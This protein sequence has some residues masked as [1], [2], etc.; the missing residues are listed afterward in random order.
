[1]AT[2]IKF[3]TDEHIAKAVIRGLRQRGVDVL[4]LVEAG[5][6]GALD[7]KHLAFALQQGR[8]IFTQ[9][10]D[11]L[12]FHGQG[13]EHAGIVYAPQGTAIGVIIRGLMLIH[14]VLEVE[15]M[16]NHVEFI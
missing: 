11:F 12:R 9:D 16:H 14:D 8:V 6:L 10:E 2:P 7:E 1:M 13:L 4:S 5:M 15:D 3:Y